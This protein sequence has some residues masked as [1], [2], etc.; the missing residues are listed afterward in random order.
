MSDTESRPDRP[1]YGEYATPAEVAAARGI[2]LD[3]SNEH[4][5]KLAAPLPGAA[6]KA[7]A[8]KASPVPRLRQAAPP[9]GRPFAARRPAQNSTLITVLLLVFG[10]WNTA[11]SIPTFLDLG[12]TLSQGLAAA[13][14]APITFGA[15]AHVV[16][17]L[18]IVFSFLVLLAAIGLSLRRIRTGRPSIWIPLVAGGVWAAGL[19]IG[20]IVVVANTPGAAAIMQNHS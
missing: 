19:V 9:S 20:M 11:T 12:T 18:L 16:G 15:T 17:I 14:Y 13:G 3:R 8:P 2:P 10:I 1:Q 7:T 6:A 5:D 4:V